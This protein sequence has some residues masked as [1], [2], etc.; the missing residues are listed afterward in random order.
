MSVQVFESGVLNVNLMSVVSN[1]GEIYF[2]TLR[3]PWNTWKPFTQS[4]GMYGVKTNLNGVI[5]PGV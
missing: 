1:H 3:R 4:E 5:S 2:K